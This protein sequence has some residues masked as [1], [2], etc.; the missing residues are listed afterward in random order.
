M[1]VYALNDL[2]W[3]YSEQSDRSFRRWV[4]ILAIPF[5]VIGLVV[6]F[7][8]LAASNKAVDRRAKP[9]MPS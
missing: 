3:G 7:L 1:S 2:F 5:L 4:M 9:A 6:P 8:K